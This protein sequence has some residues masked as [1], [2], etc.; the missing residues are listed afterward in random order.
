MKFILRLQ[1][2][3][4]VKSKTLRKRYGTVLTANVRNLMRP[5][6]DKVKVRWLWDKIELVFPQPLS[7][8]ALQQVRE[9]LACI[10]GINHLEEVIDTDFVDFEQALQFVLDKMANQLS[11]RTFAVRVRR[12]G[13]H[14]F[15]S[16]DM[17]MYLGGGIR[18]RVPSTK[19]QLTNPEC[20]VQLW[21]EQDKLSLLV[22]RFEGLGGYP[23]PTQETVVSL[24]SGGFD[25][26]VASY[27]LIRRGARTHFC[28]FDLGGGGAHEAAVQ[29]VAYYI[30]KKYSSTHP[31]KF[32]SVDLSQVVEAILTQPEQGVMG[33][34]L[35]RAMLRAG[36]LVAVRMRAQALVTGEAVGQVSSQTLSNLQVIDEVTEKLVIRPL[37]VMDKQ[38]IVDV[39]RE[40][41][42][43]QMAA[44]IPEYCGVI[45]NKPTVK[46]KRDV[47]Q[48][49]EVSITDEMIA[50]AVENAVVKDIREAH[51]QPT[52]YMPPIIEQVEDLPAGTV[53][54]DIRSPEEE[55][56]RPL[57]VDVPVLHIPFFKLA[58]AF[59]ALEQDKVYALYCQQGVMSR[60]QAI[61]LKEQGVQG[62]VLYE[63]KLL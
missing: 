14:D 62:L 55:E 18:A 33:V 20:T 21:L 16:Q 3:I 11:H 39:A 44:A 43:E 28:F 26:A 46:A 19:V 9:M 49:A 29:E 30:W 25:S 6:Q 57:Q 15:S 52:A 38:Q 42:V 1:P 27:Q 22:E 7:Q 45:S 56:A 8:Q 53:I 54:I 10:P 47:I 34:L 48:L 60:L 23:L 5:I 51:Q 59:E 63:P 12:R 35:K 31:V 17:A 2:E 50:A 61:A 4:T 32:I 24:I 37:I 36:A 58:R 41:G 40:I 13:Q